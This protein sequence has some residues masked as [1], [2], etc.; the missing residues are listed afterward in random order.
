MALLSG[1]SVFLWIQARRE[2]GASLGR[3]LPNLSPVS[4]GLSFKVPEIHAPY[5]EGI[6]IESFRWSIVR[7]ERVKGR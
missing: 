4:A 2:I 6:V 5:T 1:N 3:F 7:W